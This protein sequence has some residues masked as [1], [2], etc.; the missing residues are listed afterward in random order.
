MCVLGPSTN[1]KNPAQLEPM[2]LVGWVTGM[3]YLWALKEAVEHVLFECP[4]HDSQ[5]NCFLHI[6][7]KQVPSSEDFDAFLCSSDLTKLPSVW[8]R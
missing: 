4:L 5:R 1:S 2:M 3:L 8:K 7:L 6:Y